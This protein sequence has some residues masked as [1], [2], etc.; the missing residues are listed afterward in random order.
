MAI[1]S[2]NEADGVKTKTF[3]A[4]FGELDLTTVKEYK[5]FAFNSLAE[6]KPIMANYTILNHTYV[7]PAE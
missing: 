7:A 5:V 3:T 2:A 4:D 6:C 1:D